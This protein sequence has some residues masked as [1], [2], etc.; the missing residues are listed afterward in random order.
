MREFLKILLSLSVSGTFLFLIVF[1]IVQ[2]YRNRLSRCWQYYIWILV[3]LRFLIPLTFTHTVT[4]FLFRGVEQVV[5]ERRR[6]DVAESAEDVPE[7]AAVGTDDVPGNFAGGTE[8][9]SADISSDAVTVSFQEE[10]GD[11]QMPALSFWVFGIWAAGV[12][13]LLI[14]KI[15]IYQS[16]MQFLRKGNAEVSDLKSLNLLAEAE[17]GLKIKRTIELY[18]N[19]LITSPI[20]T[21]LFRPKIVIPD[22]KMTDG[23]LSCIFTHELV[24]FKYFDMFY[25]WLV[26]ITICIHWFNP[27]VYLLGK[28]VNRRCELSCDERVIDA[29]DEQ[30]R[31]DYGDTL[32]SFLKKGEA[33]QNTLASITLTEGAEQLI[34]R[35]GAIMDY[36]KKSKAIVVLTT[37]L[38]V[39]CCFFF[40]G[41]GA[42]AGAY[43]GQ[44][45][46][47]ELSELE[48]EQDSVGQKVEELKQTHYSYF[49][50]TY[51][52]EPYVIEFGWN[53]GQEAV[54]VYAHTEIL[55]EDQSRM[56]VFFA[57]EAEKWMEDAAAMEAVSR[58]T[59]ELKP[60]ARQKYG[61]KL[62]L[63]YVSRI[64]YLPADEIED[65]AKRAFEND[66]LA[67]FAAV[68]KMLP[69]KVREGYCERSYVEDDMGFFSIIISELD[70]DYIRAFAERCYEKEE[71][72]YFSI[73]ADDLTEKDRKE[74]MEKALRE[75]NDTY[76]YILKDKE[77]WGY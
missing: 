75:D 40:S 63:P 35:L 29:L 74:L 72:D 32:L 67:N 30:E 57:E 59:S 3:V 76:Y 71:L 70:A 9:S 23:E 7:S 13:I 49:Q 54:K 20:M 44:R 42:Y 66:E 62:E 2:M 50:Q 60:E 28:E 22:K 21:G 18:R 24:H 48:E 77:D 4:G 12:L 16:Y 34:E 73:A 56:T 1:L 41:I 11:R 33:Y 69:E 17:E 58:L 61:I 31:K 38:T 27:F 65:F 19:P 45:D 55:L 15:T 52:K 25:K 39:L 51:Y 36:R 43:A 53:L 46:A 14:R 37:A 47:E 8:D 68:V 6:A 5:A 10:T 64:V 26:Q